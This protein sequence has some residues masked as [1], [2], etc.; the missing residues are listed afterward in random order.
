MLAVVEGS[1]DHAP[2]DAVGATDQ[3]DNDVD[4]GIGGHRRRVLVPAHRGQIDAAVAAPIAGGNR[5]DNDPAA[6]PLSQQIGL[7]VEQL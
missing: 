5:R 7:P 2:G 3:L 4:L 6:G 1:I